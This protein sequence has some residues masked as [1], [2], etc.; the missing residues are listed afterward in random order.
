[1]TAL[2]S[3]PRWPAPRWSS[4][5]TDSSTATSKGDDGL[6]GGE[7]TFI[8]CSFWLVENLAL[9]GETGRTREL[10]ER[11]LGYAND[12]GLL[13]EEVDPVSSGSSGTS[14]RPSATSDSLAP[15][16]TWHEPNAAD[17]SGDVARRPRRRTS[18]P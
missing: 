8:I 11:L 15:P 13:A 16:S 17:M 1:M 6:P 9:A 10:F 5:L 14:A 3:E 2:G 4:P 7:A 12:V 18:T